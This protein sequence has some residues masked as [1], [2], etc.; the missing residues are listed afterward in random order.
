MF[1]KIRHQK[2]FEASLKDS[3]LYA[4]Y[5]LTQQQRDSLYATVETAA[6]LYRQNFLQEIKQYLDTSSFPFDQYTLVE[7]YTNTEFQEMLED[8]R[9]QLEARNSPPG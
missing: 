9:K 3:G 6:E 7:N 4:D 8:V 2:V 1:A 5:P